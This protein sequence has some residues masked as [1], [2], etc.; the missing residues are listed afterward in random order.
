MKTRVKKLGLAV[1]P[2]GWVVAA[3]LAASPG[4]AVA[5]DGYPQ[6]A[7]VYGTTEFVAQVWMPSSSY[8]RLASRSDRKTAAVEPGAASGEPHEA[9]ETSSPSTPQEDRAAREHQQWVE[10]IWNSP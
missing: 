4:T 1:L 7:E 3:A 8:T 2:L 5:D 9:T 10:S 6:A